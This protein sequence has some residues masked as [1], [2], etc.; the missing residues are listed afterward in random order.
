VANRKETDFE[1]LVCESEAKWVVAQDGHAPLNAFP[2]G[3]S[4]YSHE[5]LFI[6]RYKHENSLVVGK[7][8]PSHRV[9][10][11]AYGQNELNNRL[12]EILVI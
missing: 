3:H 11:I 8:Q 12:Y 10:Y 6:G 4:E 2:G 9:A 7:V 1:I 5:T